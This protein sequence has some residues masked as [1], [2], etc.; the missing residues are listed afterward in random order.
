MSMEENSLT[1][2]HEDHHILLHEDEE[3]ANALTHGAAAVVGVIAAIIMSRACYDRPWMTWFCCLSFVIST[4]SVFAA[5]ALSHYWISEPRVLR[6]LRAWDQGLIY[7]MIAGTY[8]PLIWRYADESF[9][10][11]LLL[12]IWVAALFG[13]GSKVLVEH[14]VNSISLTTYLLLGWLPAF[15]LFTKVPTG[16]LFCMISGGAA[17]VVGVFF[18]MNDRRIKYLHVAWHL[19]VVAG[20][21]MHFLGVY[22]YVACAS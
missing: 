3:R 1:M 10:I 14:R 4:T 20:S 21:V 12:S 2:Q 8:A 19:C 22:C 5:S 15:W 18:L 7:A 6:R 11:P 17:Y 16:L 9:R 13:F